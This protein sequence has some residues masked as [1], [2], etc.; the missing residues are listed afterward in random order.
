[1][2]GP[3]H[4]PTT[5]AYT[6]LS[7]E[8]DALELPKQILVVLQDRFLTAI[9]ASFRR[10]CIGV[11]LDLRVNVRVGGV[12]IAPIDRFIDPSNDLDVLLRHMRAVSRRIRRE[13]LA[14]T[15]RPRRG[16]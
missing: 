6:L 12:K 14:Q 11:E 3:D 15:G 13:R 5:R 8:P 2:L 10:L 1:V 4:R 9:D 7:L 16:P